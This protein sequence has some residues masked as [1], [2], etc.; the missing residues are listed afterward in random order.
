MI[1]IYETIK[2]G[3]SLFA[4]FFIIHCILIK[5]RLSASPPEEYFKR[6]NADYY[7]RLGAQ[8][9]GFSAAISILLI[10]CLVEYIH[11]NVFS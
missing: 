3:A 4:L 5:V 11:V 10:A 7:R 6:L 8:F 2:V 1:E 9:M